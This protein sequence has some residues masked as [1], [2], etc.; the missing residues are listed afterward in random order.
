MLIYK[1]DGTIDG[2]FSCVY[3]AF[4]NN[5]WPD[6]VTSS[7]NI[8]VALDGRIREINTDYVNNKRIITALYRYIGINAL[9]DI[10][11]AFRSDDDSKANIIFKYICKTFEYRKNISTKFS[12]QTVLDF[13]DT[14]RKIANEVHRMKGFLRFSESAQGFYYAHFEPDH[15]VADLL[16]PHFAMR[17]KSIPFIIHDVKRNILAMYDGKEYKTVNANQTIYVQ[18]SENEQAMQNLWQTYYSSITIKER[19][20]IKLMNAFLPVRYRTHMVEKT[21]N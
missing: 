19:K 11:Y 6:L 13:Y 15:D 9:S 5:E 7:D 12:E 16:L 1:Y 10:R 8:Q 14:I 17:F 18:L 20:N 3:M 2:I 21:C 4:T